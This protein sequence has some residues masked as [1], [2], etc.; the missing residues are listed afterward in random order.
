MYKPTIGLEIHIELNTQSK[1]FC[2]CRNNPSEHCPN[3]NICPVCMGHPGT[4]P[5]VNKEA[6]RKVIKAGLSLHCQIQKRFY[7]ER[8]NYFYPDLPKGYQ[9]SQYALPI[10]KNGYLEIFVEEQKE[11]VKKRIRIERI[12]L[13]EDVA[14]LIHTKD[15]SLIDFNRAGIPLM[16]LVTKP[17]IHSGRDARIF[18]QELQLIFRY[19]NISSADMEKGEM[20]VEVNI[21]LARI[22][23]GKGADG[24][25]NTGANQRKSA[26][27]GTKVEI[28]N[29]NSLRAVEKAI[30]Y[31]IE[32]Q[33]K[34]LN[35]GGKIIQETRGWD[36]S[37]QI[38]FSQRKKEESFDYRYFPEPDLLPFSLEDGDILKI[39]AEIPELPQERRERFKREYFLSD[40][41]VEVFVNQKDLGE[42]FEKVVSELKN[43]V[44]AK[45]NKEEVSP[46]EFRKLSKLAA[47]YILTDLQA[48]LV[49]TS[50]RGEDFLITP[51]NFAEF[52]S[53]IYTGEISSK[54]AKTVLKEMFERGGDP[55]HIIKEKGLSLM[56]DGTELVKLAE[57]VIQENPK[58]VEDY[59]KGKEPALQFLVGK[60]M[61]KTKGTAD[62]LKAKEALKK[63]L[64]QN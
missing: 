36:D 59:K 52:I 42:Y 1:M 30:D 9:I 39:A 23:T 58:P 29:L 26:P 40:R 21:S 45:E 20:R 12:H 64:N 28:K 25:G 7:F 2:S 18:A 56:T 32:R 33:S 10:N 8:K 41:E 46:N 19:L 51:E 35:D 60:M 31:E 14:K 5:V 24:R 55:S 13:E 17:D 53:L 22:E 49:K 54:I 6:V 37:K 16:E 4:L 11:A 57:I 44:K 3:V 47:N 38:T 27:L 62:P 43:W 61:A 50:V 34:V 48:L 63:V 15:G